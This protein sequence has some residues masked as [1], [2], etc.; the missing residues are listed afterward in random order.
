MTG[1]DGC[2]P[3]LRIAS[4]GFDGALRNETSFAVGVRV[5]AASILR[6]GV[7]EE[8]E[9]DVEHKIERNLIRGEVA[10]IFHVLHKW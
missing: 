1:L 3:P 7:V 6:L 9:I 5:A 4:G 10:K 8:G 2:W